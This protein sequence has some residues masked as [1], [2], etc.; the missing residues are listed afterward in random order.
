MSSDGFLPISPNTCLYHRLK[1]LLGLYV[2]WLWHM[3]HKGFTTPSQNECRKSA[4][5]Q[6]GKVDFLLNAHSMQRSTA[7]HNGG[8]STSSE[9]LSH[10]LAALLCCSYEPSRLRFALFAYASNDSPW[11]ISKVRIPKSRRQCFTFSVHGF[12]VVVD[13]VKL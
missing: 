5:L 12:V 6:S 10:R 13:R 3:S 9:A 2:F 11:K 1:L 4:S 8:K 7:S